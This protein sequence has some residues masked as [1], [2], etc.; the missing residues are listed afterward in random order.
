MDAETAELVAVLRQ[1]VK[2]QI[3]AQRTLLSL[4][5]QLDDRLTPTAEEAQGNG[6]NG[7]IKVTHKHP[8]FV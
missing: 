7:T 1:H 4:L 6:N 8:S 2:S 3:R 5:S